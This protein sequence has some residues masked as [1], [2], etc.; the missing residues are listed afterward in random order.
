[1]QG[2]ID[3]GKQALRRSLFVAGGAVDLAG[4]KQPADLARLKA[5][6]QL[7]GSK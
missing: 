7:R 4:K 2:G 6:F 5:A 3:P 1:L